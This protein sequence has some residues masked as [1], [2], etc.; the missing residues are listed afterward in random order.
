MGRRCAAARRWTD[1]GLLIATF[2]RNRGGMRLRGAKVIAAMPSYYAKTML[3]AI[4]VLLASVFLAA[5]ARAQHVALIV[6]G[7]PITTYD[8]EQRTKFL[9]IT[10]HKT[11]TRQAVIDELI[12][13]KL[14]IQIG[15]RYKLEMTDAEVDDAY[16][17][18]AKRM[19]LTGEQL[20]QQLARSG[21]DAATLKERTRAESVWQQIVRG[22]FQSSLQINDKDVATALET[23]KGDEKETFGYQY[24]LR[25]ILFIVARGAG[26]EAVENRKREAEALRSRFETCDTGLRLARSSRDVVVREPIV[27]S[28]ADLAP[29]LRAILDK[30]PIGHL[31]DPEVTAQGVELFAL[32]TKKE[33]KVDNPNKR[34]VQ[35]EIFAARFQAQANRFL[36]ELRKSA[37]I[38]IKDNADAKSAGVNPR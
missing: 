24:T 21:I 2:R 30:T 37:M 28:S 36:K 16:S 26:S 8:I 10:T 29:E 19:R 32:C 17:G 38:E 1:H 31:T 22:K 20:T 34:E 6:N 5:P 13:E 14:K 15:K 23:R 33:T 7:D 25:P 35:N 11:P 9:Q 3:T 4:A 27:K 18:I 12:D